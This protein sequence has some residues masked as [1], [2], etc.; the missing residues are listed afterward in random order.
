MGKFFEQFK[1]LTF[2]NEAEVSQNFILPLLIEFLGYSNIEIIP[3][4][5][6]PAQDIYS[7][8]NFSKE[9]SKGLTH[10][11]DFII[12]IDGD[13]SKSRLI[14]DSKGPGQKLLD[15]IGQLKSYATSVG[16]NFLMITNGKELLVYDVNNLIFRAE[17]LEDLQLKL[18]VLISLI[19]R[20]N[21][22]SK[23]YIEILKEFNYDKAVSLS[24]K[25][26][27][28]EKN[29]KRELQISDFKAYL[30]AVK[31][32]YTNWH[33]PS[34]RFKAISN[35]ELKK[36][37]PNYLLHF[38][39][40]TVNEPFNN[41]EKK[42][43]F[44]QI[45]S[46]YNIY[47]KVFVGETGS[48][49]TSFL[50]FLNYRTAE[51]ALDGI[52]V[53]IPIYIALREIGNGYTLESLISDALIRYGY[54][55]KDFEERNSFTQ[56]VF[57]LDAFDEIEESFKQEVC[58]AIEN[59]SS[60]YECYI[61]T[62]PNNLPV[63]SNAVIFDIC[64]LNDSQVENVAR[65]YIGSGYYSL[66][67]QIERNELIPE[68]RNTLLVLFMISL[69]KEKNYLPDSVA[70][71][72]NA[73][74]DRVKLWQDSRN[75][76]PGRLKWEQI[77][78]IL[79]DFAF[80]IFKNNVVSI[81]ICEAEPIIV[82]RLNEFEQKRKIN[83]GVTIN[84]VIEELTATGLI[85][86]GDDHLFFW[87]R[88]F[89][90]HFAALALENNLNQIEEF[91]SD[92]K[93]DIPIIN[94]ASRV[95]DV[96]TIV[97]SLQKRLW[98]AAYCLNENSNC[99][100]EI[101]NNVVAKLIEQVESPVPDN[102]SNAISFLEKINHENVQNFLM[103]CFE[104]TQYKDVKMMCLSAMAINPS[105]RVKEIIF[106]QIDW[107]ESLF[108]HG[109]SSQAYI[110]Q[111]L[112]NFGEHG[113]HQILSNWEKY[114]NYILDE[115]C[116]KIF[117]RLHRNN[118]LNQSLIDRLQNL[119]LKEFSKNSS[120]SAKLEAIADILSKVPNL[121]FAEE[122][123]DIFVKQEDK[124]PKF[125][126]VL[127]LLKSA[128]YIQ[129]VEKIKDVILNEN[130]NYY[131]SE[132]L[133]KVLKYTIT[134]VPK[135]IFYELIEHKNINVACYCLHALSRFPYQDVESE[136]EKHLY[137]EQP[138]LQ[139]WALKILADNG[140]IINLI[141]EDRFPNH[142][143]IPT[144]HTL[145]EAVRRFHL[146]EAMPLLHNIHDELCND[147]M[148]VS[149]SNLAYELAGTFSYIGERERQRQIISLFFDG[150]S[151][152]FKNDKYL[153]TNLMKNLKYYEQ[154]L[155]LQIAKAFYNLYLPPRG[156]FS[157][158]T[159]V[160]IETAEDLG[161]EWM[162]EKIK[163]LTDH[164]LNEIKSY[165]KFAP[166]LIERTLRALTKIGRA[167]DEDWL[168]EKLP[169]LEFDAG[170]EYNQLRR[171]IE[172]F[173]LIGSKKALPLLLKMSEKYQKVDS[174]MNILQF[175]YNSICAREKISME[176][177]QFIV[178]RA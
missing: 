113:Y 109:R 59:L 49:K 158:E 10:R 95:K 75:L 170:A 21:Q 134:T 2:A 135:E 124:F 156:C 94:L 99:N 141:R 162:R 143:F 22:L 85:I 19:G 35:I 78:L 37:D 54:K 82:N 50:K 107:D 130:L 173:A 118:C 105:K 144:A 166:H 126:G 150:T 176:G 7:G 33:L 120:Y 127:K 146:I 72:V 132:L 51:N 80:W 71:V 104:K 87:H 24:A 160:F 1:E 151:F 155:A 122:V 28:S 76:Q 27:I 148:Y 116:K 133:A 63:L 8:V 114:S 84:E 26:I 117:Q 16:N 110:V 152:L 42:F 83:P 101:K 81:I 129:L 97:N 31:E 149:E 161:G 68:S 93:W 23:S 3:E 32:K 88:L 112:S 159:E 65:Q 11:P 73:L 18:D 61:T 6:F 111:A 70:K 106:S 92:E 86:A 30:K 131:K 43:K 140:K 47:K 15:H 34:D 64:P 45:E 174:V 17:G 62:R 89:L 165:D 115:T 175:T 119:F 29:L 123:L 164:Y 66:Q 157:Y 125:R 40:H 171:G 12:C 74:V 138:Q 121:K 5:M 14:I 9:G 79:G 100:Y 52:D 48:G 55:G 154:D 169:Y 98:L 167:E 153:Q 163:N 4:K 177:G 57:F 90:N 102:R 103:D 77:S 53:K 13:Y 136:I 69:Y 172:C 60:Q 20:K 96:T 168:L 108:F 137:G 142:F 139:C 147:N 44:V 145:L 58:N 25:E 67:R 178:T 41:E 46:T 128:P 38:K 39:L 56:F 91:S 36:I